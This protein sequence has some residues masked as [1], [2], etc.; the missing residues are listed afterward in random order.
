MLRRSDFDPQADSLVRR[1]MSRLREK[2]KQYYSKE[3]DRDRVCIRHLGG[4]LL[5]FAWAD[6]L[7]ADTHA[8]TGFPCLLILP[9]RSHPDLNLQCIRLAEELSILLGEAGGAALVSPTTAMSYAGRIGDLREFAAECDA[10][11]V[12]EG[13]L[14]LPDVDLRA[15]LWLVNGRNGKTERSGRFMAPAPDKLVRLAVLWL[16]EQ[17][18]RLRI[19]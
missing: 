13:S 1:E 3:G 15:A 16:T 18:V 10:D 2:L 19:N 11:F 7:M 9:L 6:H 4:Y 14:D 5:G 17:M 12:L 8:E